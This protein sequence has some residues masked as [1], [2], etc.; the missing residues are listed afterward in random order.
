MKKIFLI[1]AALILFA[2]AGCNGSGDGTKIEE[3]GTIE[4][5]NSV[6]SSQVSG[7]VLT[8][9]TDEG[10]LVSLN[11]TLLIID[12]EQL[13]IQL[14]QA[15]AGMEMAKAQLDLLKNGARKEDIAQAKQVMNQAKINFDLA[16]SDKDRMQNL[17]NEKSI[18]KKQYDDAM[19]RF[20]VTKSQ[21]ESAK[22]N[23]TK[24][25]HFARP[26]EI[27]Q[28]KANYDKAVAVVDLV[29]KSIRD[30]FVTAP[31]K[32][33]VVKKFVEKGEMVSPMTSLLKLSDLSSVDLVIYVSETDL[34]KVKL[35][36]RAEV[37]VDTYKD[38]SFAGKVIYISPEA[39]FTPKNIQTK[40]ERTKL[41]F[42]V[43]IEIPNPNYELKAGMP[44]D[45]T[46]YFN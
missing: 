43:K 31:I 11:D 6:I 16:Q 18:T 20:D 1:P 15:E 42:A 38:K 21:Y 3:S 17:Y 37:K 34:G 33:Y 30:S 13:D 2:L 32:G 23:Y 39:E 8:L 7:K 35:G 41:V 4:A 24:I 25:T 9:L 10:K 14:E 27:A 22:E 36:Q 19:A 29:K 12:H 44:A 26:E 46:V 40:D 28:A 5:T 45:A